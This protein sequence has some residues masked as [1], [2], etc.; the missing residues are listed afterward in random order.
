M[1]I[2]HDIGKNIGKAIEPIRAG[3]DKLASRKLRATEANR[4]I[5]VTSSAFTDGGSLPITFTADGAGIAP[6]IA[7]NNIPD[8]ARSIVLIAED[9]DAPIPNPFVHWL[10]YGL[11]VTTSSIASSPDGGREGKNSM[12]KSGYAPASP[13]AGHGVHH[14]HFQVFALDIV[15][16]LGDGAGRNALLDAMKNHVL[17]WGDIVATYER[18]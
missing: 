7:W 1:G 17:A 16:E 8:G 14:Y 3:D 12:L 4:T 5:T 18:S 13:P 11:P 6:P 2:A 10:V 9:P 15:L